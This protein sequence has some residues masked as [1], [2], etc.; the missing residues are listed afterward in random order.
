MCNTIS[1]HSGGPCINNEGKVLGILSRCDPVEE[2]RCYLVPA[3]EIKELYLKA[4][5][6]LARP[7]KVTTQR[8][9]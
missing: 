1:G 9:I 6:M 5:G 7:E 3:T 4:K 8:T 2:Q